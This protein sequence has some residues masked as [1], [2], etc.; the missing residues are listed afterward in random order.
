MKRTS[1]PAAVCLILGLVFRISADA[2]TYYVSSSLGSDENSGTSPLAPWRTLS[3]VNHTRFAT[4][5]RIYFL[6]GD[7]WD[8]GF[9]AVDWSGTDQAHA[10]IGAYRSNADGT[11]SYG[12]PPDHRRPIINDEYQAGGET[13]TPATGSTAGI[14]VSGSHVDIGDIEVEQSGWGIRVQGDHQTDVTI[15]DVFING[16]YQCGIQANGVTNLTIQ[17]SELFNA[18]AFRGIFHQY[19]NWCSTVGIQK[20]HNIVVQNNFIHESWGEG[21]NAFYGSTNAVI[22]NNVLY[23]N[24]AAGIYVGALNGAD[25]YGNLILGTND[26]RFWRSA[27]SAG[28]GIA[29]DNESYEFAGGATTSGG[30][31]TGNGS[32]CPLGAYG[33]YGGEGSVLCPDALQNIRI[34]DNLVGGNSNGLGVWYADYPAAY[35]HVQVLNNTFVDN[36]QQLYLGGQQA[37]DYAVRNNIF[38]SLSPGMTDVAGSNYGMDFDANYW[39][40]GEPKTVGS[41]ALGSAAD[42]LGGARL[43][44]MTG[45]RN[46]A[47]ADQVTAAA[48]APVVG[49]STLGGA[50]RDGMFFDTDFFGHALRD[51]PDLGAIAGA[52]SAPPGAPISIGPI[53]AGSGVSPNPASPGQTITV[54]GSFTTATS[55]SHA[56]LYF[57]LAPPG[58]HVLVRTSAVEAFRAGVATPVTT[59]IRV[60]MDAAPGN[61]VI[62]AGAYDRSTAMRYVADFAEVLIQ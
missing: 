32:L 7:E 9:L 17:N 19:G 59:T 35:T 45:W 11:V 54:S 1:L 28:P 20:S 51:P 58:G 61:Y 24:W 34:Y 33:N 4:S 18:E 48:F 10:I 8:H 38:L 3:K 42:V 5:D 44:L 30:Q 37:S 22:R 21:I 40:Q 52:V 23:A 53:T 43:A 39:S 16:A 55:A 62:S 29:M 47:T 15:D 12:A 26:K 25:I 49:S 41:T 27:A 50:T 36:E 2:S 46:I 14:D 13:F 60:P 6:A 31:S 57:W 56:I